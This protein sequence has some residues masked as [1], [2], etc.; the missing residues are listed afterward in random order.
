MIIAR[1]LAG[2]ESGYC[3]VVGGQIY[4]AKIGE[5]G[6][7]SSD[8]LL[9]PLASVRLLAPCR[10]TKVIAVGLNYRDPNQEGQ[11]SLPNEPIISI[12][13]PSA[14]IGTDAAIIMPPSSNRVDFEG[15]LAVVN[16]RR[17][18]NVSVEAAADYVLGYTCGN[19]VTARDIQR[20][21]GQ[22]AKAKGFDTFCPLGPWIATGID[23]VGGALIARVNGLVRQSI[24]TDL[25]HFRPHDLVSYV[26]KIMTLMPGDVI[27]TGTPPGF[28]PLA[29]GDV[30]E[31]EIDG[32]GTLRNRV[33]PVT[34]EL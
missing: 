9:G 1:F 22:W 33:S 34:D 2:D 30:V 31:I 4:R 10:P 5:D 14:V 17:A 6:T 25:L 11:S 8:S 23:P 32:I 16:G 3:I 15:E 21:E 18:K 27:L 24:T 13:P 19:D 12:K 7:Y 20:R 29:A 28:G 26:S